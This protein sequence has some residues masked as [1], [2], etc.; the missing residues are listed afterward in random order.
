M[1]SLYLFFRRKTLK[2]RYRIAKILIPQLYNAWLT[3][4]IKERPMIRFAE[5][6]FKD[7]TGLVGVEIGVAEGANALNILKTLP[8]KRLYLVDP[9]DPHLRYVDPDHEFA[10]GMNKIE[11]T[12]LHYFIAKER[13]ATFF[14]Q[15]VFIKKL[16]QDAIK[17]IQELVDFVYIDGNHAY[18]YVKNDLALYYKIVKPNGIIGGHDYT[19]IWPGVKKASSEFAAENNLELHVEFPDWWIIKHE[20]SVQ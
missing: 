10:C 1:N 5:S 3:G 2:L 11:D 15:I 9:Y 19:E 14:Q 6:H 7:L 16:S 13:L 18:E 12:L 4:F 20:E 8:M 17:D